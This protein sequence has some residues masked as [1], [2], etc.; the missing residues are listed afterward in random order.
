MGR[1]VFYAADP[2]CPVYGELRSLA[3][4]TAGAPK[5]LARA[6]APLGPEIQVA[7]IFGSLA[8][9]ESHRSS[10]IDVMIIGTVS[11]TAVARALADPQRLLH[12]EINPVVYSRSEFAKKLAGGHHFVNSV[13]RGPKVFLLGNERE[14]SRVAEERM[15]SAPQGVAR[16]DRGI[17]RRDRPRSGRQR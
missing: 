7:F 16:R 14:L 10:D 17:A 9:G 8:R 15:D 1:Q 13:M 4:K 12:R 11:F 2:V 6:L 3:F 5:R